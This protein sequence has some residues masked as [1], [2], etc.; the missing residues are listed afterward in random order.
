MLSCCLA[1]FVLI[2][3]CGGEEGGF[4]SRAPE[5]SSRPE[6]GP[7]CGP[8]ESL[9]DARLALIRR[10]TSNLEIESIVENIEA[11]QQ[12]VAG[13]APA[14][15]RDEV[16]LTNQVYSR[17]ARIVLDESYGKAPIEE[18]TSDEYNEAALALVS[19]CFQ[20]PNR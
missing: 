18:I 2:A 10:A 15:L 16:Q 4:L 14:E 20:N 8:L 1:L 5:E 19:F 13:E 3:A 9:S 7:F 17:Y 11:L 6:G 12:E